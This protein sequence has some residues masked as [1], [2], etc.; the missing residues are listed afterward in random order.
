MGI[1]Q[2]KGCGGGRV[3]LARM[4]DEISVEWEA[5]DEN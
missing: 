2:E 3:P 4:G 1:L 5:Q